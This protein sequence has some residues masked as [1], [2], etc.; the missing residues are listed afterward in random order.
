MGRQNQ[1]RRLYS[2][3]AQQQDIMSYT[4]R[5]RGNCGCGE[6]YTR[7]PPH[8][9]AFFS[10][11]R[12]WSAPAVRATVV[13]SREVAFRHC[14]K[15][16]MCCRSLCCSSCRMAQRSEHTCCCCY[17]SCCC[18]CCCIRGLATREGQGSL[19]TETRRLPLLRF[20]QREV[21]K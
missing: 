3:F 7:P 4:K 14:C 6:V 15:C 19:A 12:S 2:G 18:C 13:M 5:A 17:K 16:C 8:H 11:E 10:L 21:H 9:W 20:V 1:G